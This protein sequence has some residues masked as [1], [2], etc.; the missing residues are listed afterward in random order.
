M[1]TCGPFMEYSFYSFSLRVLICA[2]SAE[3]I[4]REYGGTPVLR[5]AVLNARDALMQCFE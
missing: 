5:V 3:T 2:A 4:N 1:L